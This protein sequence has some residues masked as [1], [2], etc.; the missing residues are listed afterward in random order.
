MLNLTQIDD[1]HFFSFT[2]SLDRGHILVYGLWQISRLLILF[3]IDVNGMALL[4]NGPFE[5]ASVHNPI[6]HDARIL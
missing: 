1:S 3:A 2:L 4:R 6:D 5:T